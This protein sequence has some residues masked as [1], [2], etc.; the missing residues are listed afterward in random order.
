MSQIFLVR[1]LKDFEAMLNRDE[2]VEIKA[3]HD[4]GYQTELT[5]VLSLA[6]LRIFRLDGT[7]DVRYAAKENYCHHLLYCLTVTEE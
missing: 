6:D 2:D 7:M 1:H 4:V 5:A 3:S